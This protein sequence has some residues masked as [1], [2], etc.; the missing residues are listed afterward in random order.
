MIGHRHIQCAQVTVSISP[1]RMQNSDSEHADSFEFKVIDSDP[2][3]HDVRS[4]IVIMPSFSLVDE[5]AAYYYTK[6]VMDS[7]SVRYD[8]NNVGHLV[9]SSCKTA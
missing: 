6:N 1:L 4:M 9:L 5:E 2:A 3:L 8:G 7:S